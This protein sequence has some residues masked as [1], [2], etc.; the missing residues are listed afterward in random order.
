MPEFSQ[1]ISSVVDKIRRHRS[2]YEQ[3]EM[4]TRT[5]VIEPILEV[6]GWDAKDPDKVQP[7]LAAEEGFPDYSLLLDG[8]KVLFIEA[9]KMSVDV[10]DR[11]VQ[12][13]LGKYL[14]GEGM[15]YGLL[16]N[17]AVWVLFRA[18]RE[19]T[20]MPERVVWKVDIEHDEMNAIASKLN[21][22]AISNIPNIDALLAKLGILD[23]VWQSLLEDPMSLTKGVVPVF[24][25]IANEAYP[26]YHFTPEEVTDFIRERLNEIISP[27]PNYPPVSEGIPPTSEGPRTMTIGRDTFAIRNSYDILVNSAEWLIKQGKLRRE[28]C[29]VTSGHKRYLV[30]VQPKHRYGDPFRAPKQLS[31][32]LYIETHYSTSG[33]I[34]NAKRLLKHFGFDEGLLQV[35]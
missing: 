30:N 23:E 14:F 34:A 10:E 25:S 7:N 24:L 19:G 4:A 22:V 8:K 2:L 9:K 29:P 13:Q 16:T 21:T 18:F 31:N 35:R 28:H 17:G 20:R 27:E 5:Q 12:N 3:N 32:G 15:S 1:V 11:N 26:G 6:L 33:C